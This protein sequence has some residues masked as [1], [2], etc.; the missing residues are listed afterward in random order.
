MNL[1][2][3]GL[4][5]R[6]EELTTQVEAIRAVSGPLRLARDEMVNDHRQAEQDADAEIRMAEEGLFDA[7]QER[8]MIVRAL[9]GKTSVPE[10]ETQ[11]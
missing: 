1:T 4:R 10:G 6:F 3:E 7:E 5:A 2:K 9:N 11:E 8:A